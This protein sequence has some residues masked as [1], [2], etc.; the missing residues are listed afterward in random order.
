MQAGSVATRDVYSISGRILLNGTDIGADVKSVRV[1]REIPEALPGA[2]A[3]FTA[4]EATVVADL[5]NAVSLVPQHPW[6]RAGGWPP[7]P[8]D[9]VEVWLN[10]G[11][12]EWCQ[13]KG[14]VDEPSGDTESA[15]VEFTVVDRYALLNKPASIPA[16]AM[17]MPSLTDANTYRYIGLQSVYL[18]DSALRQAGRYCTPFKS[19]GCFF[20]APFQGSTWPETGNLRTSVKRTPDSAG[21]A[22]P[23]WVTTA[24]GLGVQNVE[25]TYDPFIWSGATTEFTA[26]LEITQELIPTTGGSSWT[27]VQFDRGSVCLAMN[28]STIFARYYDVDGS[29]T[30][31]AT[32]A[33][34][35]HQRVTA[36]FRRLS[37]GVEGAL[38]CLTSAGTVTQVVRGTTNVGSND[39]KGPVTRIRVTGDSSIGATQAAY[40]TQDWQ[41]LRFSPSAVIHASNT[42]RNSL[43]G[44]PEQ[45]NVPAADMLEEIADAEFASWWIDELGILQWWDRAAFINRGVAATLDADDHV[46]KIPWRHNRGSLISKAYVDYQATIVTYRWRT[47]LTLWQGSGETFNQGDDEE[48]IISVPNDEIWFGV[49]VDNP[50]R[51]SQNTPNYFVINRGIRSVI[52]GIAVGDNGAERQTNSI[53]MTLRRITDSAYAYRVSINALQANEQAALELPSEY[54]TDT[55]LWARWR[56]S[57]LP[58]LRGK[59][60]IQFIDDRAQGDVS[61]PS[62]APDYVHDVGWRIQ[63]RSYAVSTAEYIASISTKD[64]PVIE[65]IEIMPVFNL[66]VGDII[67]VNDP[68]TMGISIRA[69]VTGNHIDADFVEGSADQR[70]DLRP[71]AVTKNG[72]T[73][74]DFGTKYTGTWNDFGTERSGETWSQFGANPLNQK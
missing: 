35:T 20:S 49:D 40:P 14:T 28:S 33:R 34:S 61:G 70:L 48:E 22:Y 8:A 51:Y 19:P 2:S 60:K 18:V 9:T 25:A 38:C 11:R 54:T 39:L 56:G 31:L 64:Q 43:T 26:P 44:V 30:D 29:S 17:S 59:K 15:V 4:A 62:L 58:I 24:Y 69:I 41:T 13:I 55:A 50:T 67:T 7:S 1:D 53:S 42:G 16:L 5:S 37:S 66:Q 6:N 74:A 36:K 46:R 68:N 3:K 71:L 12:N 65:G 73:W 21:Q 63:N 23:N 27:Y 45:L 72:A 32:I 47:D 57:G 10:D 52:G